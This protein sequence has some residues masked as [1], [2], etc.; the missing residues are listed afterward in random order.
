LLKGRES[1]YPE[2]SI[3]RKIL[4]LFSERKGTVSGE[5]LSAILSVSRT[6]VWKHINALRSQGYN[7]EA[8]HSSGYRLLSTPDILSS[9]AI[10]A[11]LA[12]KRLGRQVICLTETGS[13]NSEAFRLAEE[14]ADEG[15]VLFAES[16]LQGKGRL[17][18]SWHSPAG[19]NLYCSLILRPPIQPV[20]AFQL[21]FLSAVAVA[22][23]IESS[24]SICPLIKWPNDILLN[25]KKIAGLLNEM[26]A[27]TER[28]N[29]VILGIGVN[30][31]M[32]LEQYP[33]DL[34]HPATSLL[35]ESGSEINRLNFARQLLESL[36]SLYDGYLAGGY[37]PVR[38][39]WVARCG[40]IG[41]RVVVNGPAEMIEGIATGID[42]SGALL[43]RKESGAVARVLAGDVRIV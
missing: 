23:A 41:K 34:R 20:D 24:I 2:H 28:V 5:E 15:T 19:V 25:G 36:D 1:I 42:D 31:N 14:G 13:T 6:A 29:F 37:P 32:R 4:E 8:R 7:I 27:E 26:S 30:L 3:D 18:R 21:T 11:G 10:T 22:R 43:V 17:G 40:M 39:E 9:A 35:I 12:T 33:D 16:Q 38:E